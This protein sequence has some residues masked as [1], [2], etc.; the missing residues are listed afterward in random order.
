[1]NENLDLAKLKIILD[2]FSK[3]MA[4]QPTN[5]LVMREFAHFFKLRRYSHE[6]FENYYQLLMRLIVHISGRNAQSSADTDF[7]KKAT[8][9]VRSAVTGRL[10]ALSPASGSFIHPIIS[11]IEPVEAEEDR[12]NADLI[13][14]RLI[15][16]PGTNCEEA[17]VQQK[18]R[19]AS[20]IAMRQEKEA[21]QNY[22]PSCNV[23]IEKNGGCYYMRCIRQNCQ[24]E[25]CRICLNPW[26]TRGHTPYACP[27][28]A[29]ARQFEDRMTQSLAVLERAEQRLR[30]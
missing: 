15:P 13:E 27:N 14:T 24:H 19:E 12:E 18:A 6:I 8:C 4:A 9:K 23:K 3:K 1:M 21:P 7:S 2:G 5:Q 22:V 17:R 20:S 11:I 10:P 16:H 26:R 30:K 29:A 28:E 25:F